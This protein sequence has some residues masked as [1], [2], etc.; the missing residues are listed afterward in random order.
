MDSVYSMIVPFY[1]PF[2]VLRSQV[3][4]VNIE[5]VVPLPEEGQ[6]FLDE[7]LLNNMKT[8]FHS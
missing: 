4:F 7:H 5:V 6:T 3:N 8:G 2:L 1:Y